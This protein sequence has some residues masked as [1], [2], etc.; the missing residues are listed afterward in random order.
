M[1][2]NSSGKIEWAKRLPKWQKG[3]RTNCLSVFNYAK[4]NDL[5]IFYVDKIENFNLAENYGARIQ[6]AGVINSYKTPVTN[7]SSTIYN[8]N[9]I[10][11]QVQFVF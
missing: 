5:H 4:G 2:I 10:V 1:N 7:V 11:A 6:V 9:Q 8:S 3:T